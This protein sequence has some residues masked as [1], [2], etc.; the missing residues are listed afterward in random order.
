MSTTGFSWDDRIKLDNYVFKDLNSF[1]VALKISGVLCYDVL[2]CGVV[3]LCSGLCGS[4]A[5]GRLVCSHL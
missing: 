5:Q 4:R 1:P 3:G 2:R